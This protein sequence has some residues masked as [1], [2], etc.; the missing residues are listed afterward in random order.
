MSARF[1]GDIYLFIFI[2]QQKWPT[3]EKLAAATLEVGPHGHKSI[4]SDV[5]SVQ[6][7]TEQQQKDDLADFP[8]W[9]RWTRCGLGLDTILEGEDYTR[10]LK[11]WHDECWH[12]TQSLW[13]TTIAFIIKLQ[14]PLLNNLLETLFCE[15]CFLKGLKVLLA[16]FTTCIYYLI[17]CKCY[18]YYCQS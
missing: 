5:I 11:R 15:T 7:I 8:S 18:V 12:S 13:H 4:W 3:V 10:E 1:I 6:N 14:C 2:F 17:Y 16:T 9:R